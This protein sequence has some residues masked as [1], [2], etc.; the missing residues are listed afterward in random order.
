MKARDRHWVIINYPVVTSRG[1][2]NS[3]G[4]SHL[5]GNI[6]VYRQLGF[7]VLCLCRWSLRLVDILDG[8]ICLNIVPGTATPALTRTANQSATLKPK[9]A[10]WTHGIRRWL[11]TRIHGALSVILSPM[12]V[13]ERANLRSM[14]EGRGNWVHLIEL[15]DEYVPPVRADGYLV[16]SSYEGLDAPQFAAPWP[17]IRVAQFDAAAFQR[18]LERISTDGQTIRVMLFGTG[19]AGDLVR[20]REFLTGHSWFRGKSITLDVFG[21]VDA[22]ESRYAG[23]N[24][25]PWADEAKLSPRP[26]DAGILYYAKDI[27]DDG[28]LKVG[29]PTKLSRYVDWSLPAISNR[30][31]MSREFL[32]EFDTDTRV[33]NDAA[34]GRA[35][36][37]FLLRVRERT[38]VEHYAS[39][40]RDF[41]SHFGL[42]L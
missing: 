4:H 21:A 2:D 34:Q 18:R 29:S 37:D 14:Y 28:R 32:G 16:V 10:S 30:P 26:F 22:A 20:V 31:V 6:Q 11:L 12:I 24:V 7:R 42:P 23:I 1:K 8:A 15:N 39:Q 36:A 9:C 5:R 17:V 3:G 33:L 27:Y 25:H 19:G 41:L 13:H 40:F 35:Y 38:S